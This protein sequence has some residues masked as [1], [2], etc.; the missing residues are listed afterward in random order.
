MLFALEARGSDHERERDELRS[1][2]FLMKA[3]RSFCNGRQDG[4]HC[5]VAAD[6]GLFSGHLHCALGA[7]PCV[8]QVAAQLDC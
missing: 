5:H 3:S 2:E 4:S 8:L 1:L 7:T 6:H